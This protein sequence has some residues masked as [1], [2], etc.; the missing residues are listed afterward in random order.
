M[1]RHLFLSRE[2]PPAP[3]APGGIGTYVANMASA[4]AERGETVH[5]I[6]QQWA[7][8][9][10][11]REILNAGRLIIHRVPIDEPISVPGADTDALAIERLRASARPERAW[12]W[13]AIALAESLITTDEIDV[14]EAQDFEAPLFYLLGRRASGLGPQRLP[15]CIIHLHSPTEFV[16]R[17]NGWSASSDD[18]ATVRMEEAWCIDQADALICPSRFLAREASTRYGIGADR[19]EV[20]PYPLSMFPDEPGALHPGSRPVLYV[21]RIEARKGVF[22]F[23]HAAVAVARRYPQVRYQFVGSD[24]TA[25]D[26]E[27]TLAALRGRIPR[28]VAGR[29]RFQPSIPHPELGRVLRAARFLVVPSRWDNFPNVCLEAMSLGRP[30]MVSPNGGMTEVVVDGVNGWVATS[31]SPQGFEEALLRA[32]AA[33]PDE[34]DR[35]GHA[36][37]SEINRVCGRDTVFAQRM[38]FHRRVVRAGALRSRQARTPLPSGITPQHPRV[39]ASSALD[40][41]FTGGH[42]APPDRWTGLSWSDILRMSHGQKA[43]LLLAS[44]RDPGRVISW[45]ANRIAGR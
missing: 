13:N 37:A 6:A 35:M 10:L 15:P 8:A 33:T 31:C 44:A 4:L 18:T 17:H 3:Y 23:I 42:G 43:A 12:N 32:I 20:I 5:V 26:G 11:R 24:V 41:R 2:L 29:F 21:G 28:D 9:P 45:I 7:A 34:C 27:S 19:I 14:I 1:G 25:P 16:W 39:D 22:E 30:V 38:N 36:A 40:V